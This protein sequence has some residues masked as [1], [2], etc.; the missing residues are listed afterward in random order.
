VLRHWSSLSRDLYRDYRR[1]FG[2]PPG[3]LLAYGVMTDCDNTRT[4][5]RAWYGDIVFGPRRPE[6]AG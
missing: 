5:A 4:T 2:G 3:R 1:V 6:R